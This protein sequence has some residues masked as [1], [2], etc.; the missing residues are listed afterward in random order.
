MLGELVR[1]VVAQHRQVLGLG[2]QV[3]ADRQDVGARVADRADGLAG[4]RPTSSPRP[5]HDAALGEQPRLLRAAQQLERALE[6]RAGPHAAGTGAGTVSVLWF[7]I[8]GPGVDHGCERAPVALEV[9]DEHLDRAAGDA[10]ADRPDAGREDG[11]AAVLLVVAVDG[12]DDRVAEAHARD[13]VGHA[14]GLRRDRAARRAG[15]VLTAQKP[16]ARVQTSPRI[17]KVAVPA[18]P[19]LAEVRAVGLLA[20]RV[21]VE[22]AHEPAQPLV[23][24]ADAA[25]AP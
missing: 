4:P 7:R 19:A 20:H 21:E 25:R 1:R 14:R 2:P 13:R 8:V 22:P 6:A 5:D 17:M 23:A 11:G 18:V 24:L 12:G 15:P 10:L 9:G 16:Q 3:L